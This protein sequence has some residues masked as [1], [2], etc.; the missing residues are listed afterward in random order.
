MPEIKNTF[1]KSKMNKDVDSRLI[2]NGEYRD[3]LN[4][5]VSTSEGS[6]VGA[7]ENIRGNFELSNFG[8]TDL[9]L[10]V[11]GSFVDTANNRIYFFITNFVDGSANQL[12]NR[13]ASSASA[14]ASDGT[15]FEREGAKNCIAYCEIPYLQ[16]E[17]LNPTSITS[18]ILV[19][20]AF[21]NFSKT[22]PIN[23]VNL[24]ENLLFFTDNR[25]QPR[26]INVQTAISNPLTYYTTEDDISVAKFAPYKPISFLDHSGNSTLKN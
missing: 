4:I 7:L 25:N 8:L 18:D 13:P 11:I 23:G 6:D 22:H 16:D 24:V 15:V 17:Q 26:K 2:P 19:E 10:E 20:G 5:S 9:N 3:G 21:L 1:V 14:T 12:D